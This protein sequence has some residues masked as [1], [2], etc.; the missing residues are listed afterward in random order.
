MIAERL[1]TCLPLL[2][3]PS[4]HPLRRNPRSSYHANCTSLLHVLQARFDATPIRSATTVMPKRAKPRQKANQC[5][6]GHSSGIR[7]QGRNDTPK[8]STDKAPR[9][10]T[11]NKSHATTSRA[12][13]Q[14]HPERQQDHC[15][16]LPSATLAHSARRQSTPPVQRQPRFSP[17]AGQ[18]ASRAPRPCPAQSQG[19]CWHS[20]RLRAKAVS[21]RMRRVWTA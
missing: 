21:T 1:D 12:P 18:S 15:G 20:L 17:R 5:T 13:R 9:N 11:P 16:R 6:N 14:A 10:T 4:N 7:R 2:K 3:K 19:P 8:R